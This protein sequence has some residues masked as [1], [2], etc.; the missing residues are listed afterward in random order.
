MECKTF[1]DLFC[2]IGGFHVALASEGLECVFAS[3]MNTDA[4]E[5]YEANFGIK[6]AGDITQISADQIPPRR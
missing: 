6:P 2:G 3:E 4:A 1:I 5:S